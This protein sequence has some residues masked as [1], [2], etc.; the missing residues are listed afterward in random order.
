MSIAKFT[1]IKNNPNLDGLARWLGGVVYSEETGTKLTMEIILPWAVG[2]EKLREQRFPCVVFVQ[3]SAWTFPDVGYE[4]PQLS[5]LAKKG[6]VIATVTHRSSVDGHKAPAFLEDVKTAIRY[7]RSHKDAYQI[8]PDRI[9][10]FGTSSGGNTALLVGLTGDDETYKTSEYH[11]ESDQ[12]KTVVEC[13]GPADMFTLFKEGV[14]LTDEKGEP[15]IFAKLLGD[16]KEE[17]NKRLSMMNPY[18]KVIE[19]QQYPP[20]LIIHGDQD[21]LVDYS[22]SEMMAEKLANNKVHTELI[23]VEGAP[24]ERDFWSLEL[25]D[26]IFDYIGRTL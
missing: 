11:Q 24:H 14:P 9:G 26:H 3:G 15:S 18:E 20:F 17:Q 22:Q 6:Y 13:F 19:G 7:L 2:D 5:V 23:L 16:T 12:V 1:K 4:L 10:I 21:E 25:W 8:D